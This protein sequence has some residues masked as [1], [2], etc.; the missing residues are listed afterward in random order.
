[1]RVKS[2]IV[3]SVVGAVLLVLIATVLPLVLAILIWSL[4]TEGSRWG[5]SVRWKGGTVAIF[6]YCSFPGSYN[7]QVEWVDAQNTRRV[8]LKVGDS[9]PHLKVSPNGHV[10]VTYCHEADREFYYIRA[11]LEDLHAKPIVK[12]YDQYPAQE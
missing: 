10:V 1:M 9:V 11:V 2:V 6:D 12:K 7:N 4:P 3:L 8:L 5:E